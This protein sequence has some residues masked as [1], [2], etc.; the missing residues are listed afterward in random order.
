MIKEI[1]SGLST[2]DL[3]MIIQ[4]S[5]KATYDTVIKKPI[6]VE[7]STKV[8]K[9]KYR[10]DHIK[11]F[12]GKQNEYGDVRYDVLYLTKDDLIKCLAKIEEIESKDA[13]DIECDDLPF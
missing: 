6:Y 9:G 10:V 2:R 12:V 8:C 4:S 5:F 7:E 13:E 3:E 11:C 1:V